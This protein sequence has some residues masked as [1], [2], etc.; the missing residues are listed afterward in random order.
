MHMHVPGLFHFVPGYDHYVY[1]PGREPAFVLLLAFLLTF[2]VVRIYTRLGR[3]RGWGS[4]S[5]GGVHLHHL[6]PGILASLTAGTA[7]IA[8]DPGRA[9]MLA[10]S[11]LFGIG[12]ALTLDEF[13]LILH[14]DDVYWTNEGRSSIEAILMGAAFGGLCLL[15]TAPPDTDPGKDAPHWVIG[16]I[17][18]VNLVFALVAFLKGKL[19]LGAFGIFL[20]GIALVGAA[21]LAKPRSL[22]A[23]RFYGPAKL[24]RSVERA[25]YYDRRYAR[26][27][28]R[29]YDAIGGAPSLE[30]APDPS[31]ERTLR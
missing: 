12:A 1:R 11:A 26:I 30:R 5:V 29:I 19:R 14:L 27:Q 3:R 13:A 21:R 25:A 7:I 8:F 6:V 15:A 18:G 24:E 31:S 20:P 23:R 10:L 17:I 9:W 22:W 28:H 2:A 4:G 16:P